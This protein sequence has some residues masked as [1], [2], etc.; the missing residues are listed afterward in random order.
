MKKS[1]KSEKKY[2]VL[3]FVYF[4][5]GI[6]SLTIVDR[7]TYNIDILLCIF[8]AK[9]EKNNGTTNY[10]RNHEMCVTLDCNKVQN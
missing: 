8:I 6:S 5:K 10:N 7:D 9:R 2:I 1:E 4:T 3:I